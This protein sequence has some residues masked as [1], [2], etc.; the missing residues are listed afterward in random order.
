MPVE[1][2]VASR[3]NQPFDDRYIRLALWSQ[4]ALVVYFEVVSL[5]P[6]GRWNYQPCCPVAFDLLSQ[7]KLDAVE[8]FYLLAFVLPVVAFWYGVRRKNKWFM[9][10]ALVLYSSWLV[11]QIEGWWLPYV[12]GASESW[13]RAYGQAFSASTQVLPS[14]GDH[15]PPD[16]MHLALQILLVVAVWSG[17]VALVRVWKPRH[18]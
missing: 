6:L 1:Q 14:W 5:V 17:Y 12:F 16:G 8:V 2:Q 9:L 15:L 11:L 7:G 18:A 13:K 4:F 10:A 3:S